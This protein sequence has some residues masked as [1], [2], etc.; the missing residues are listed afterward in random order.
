[1][2]KR[3]SLLFAMVL[4]I[5]FYIYP[6]GEKK[7]ST[8][9]EFYAAMMEET[10]A[11]MEHMLLEGHN[12]NKM[13]HPGSP[14]TSMWI[15]RN[16]LWRASYVQAKLLIQYGANL[17]LR[18][19][20]A[21]VIVGKRIT[22][23]KYPDQW[24]KYADKDSGYSGGIREEEYIP[25]LTLLINSGANINAKDAPYNE[26][27]LPDITLLHNRLFEK[28]GHTALNE[29]ISQNCFKIVNLLLSHG[30]T[31]DEDT[32]NFIKRATELSGTRE[33]ADYITKL[34]KEQSNTASGKL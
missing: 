33:M 11:H 24:K 34:M 7:M 17:K 1:M 28:E 18:P 9:E 22:T 13:A 3:I 30:A 5:S 6:K 14:Y 26:V 27:C 25:Y 21:H 2:N 19:Y 12:P 15:D 23:E 10:T 31:F 20:L 4:C 8:N 16:P 29:A 32:P